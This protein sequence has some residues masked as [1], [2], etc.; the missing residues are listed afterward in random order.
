MKIV[1]CDD[2]MNECEKV[3]A[4]LRDKKL[5]NPS[6]DKIILLPPKQMRHEI[7]DCKTETWDLAIMDIEFKE[8]DFDGIVLTDQLNK[9]QPNCQVIYLTHIIDF[10]PEV[11]ETD[12]CY[13][14][15]KNN[16]EYMLPRAF[17]KAKKINDKTNKRNQI[18][19]ICNGTRQY[20]LQDAIIYVEKLQ[21]QILIHTKD[22][23]YESYQS[24]I[25]ISKQMDDE[26][27]RCHG[28]F[29][30]NLR[31]VEGLERNQISLSNGERIPVGRTYYARIKEAFM[32]YW[33]ERM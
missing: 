14:V 28:S 33:G 27:V 29:L 5:I 10:A 18:E 13:F 8:Q 30:V 3:E 12:H 19:L 15:M 24:L 25:S 31:Y 9:V 26:V 23:I 22:A 7:L 2:E 16:M 1:V 17:E 4:L 32:F 20:I 21:R 6:C 11:Y